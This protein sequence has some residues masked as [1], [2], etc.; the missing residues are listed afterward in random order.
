M[1]NIESTPDISLGDELTVLVLKG[2]GDSIISRMKDGRVI[3]FNRENV[4]FNELEPGMTV[5]AKVSFIA[6]NYIIVDPVSPPTRGEEA[7]K[8]GLQMV[9]ETENWENA[10]IANALL[11]II[12]IL[13]EA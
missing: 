13:E 10:V 12:D 5:Q 1:Y 6:Q 7:I 9:A 11:H 3:L 4:L 2:K 8:L